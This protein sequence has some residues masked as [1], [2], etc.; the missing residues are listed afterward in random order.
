VEGAAFIRA[1]AEIADDLVCHL[2]DDV[3]HPARRG[4]AVSF[5]GQERLGPRYGD[6][7]GVERRHTAIAPDYL[8]S[9]CGGL[10]GYNGRRAPAIARGAVPGFGMVGERHR[11][12][13][14]ILGAKAERTR[15]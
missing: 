7:G 13:P 4:G 9:R 12:E 14:Q 6:L 5:H 1:A 3:M 8:E 2:R 15:T 11:L 10:L